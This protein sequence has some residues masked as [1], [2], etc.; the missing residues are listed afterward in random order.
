MCRALKILC[1]APTPSNL[2]E[3]KR[4]TVSV[5]WELVGGATSDEDLISQIEAWNPDVVVFDSRLGSDVER[6]V[7]EAKETV[8]VVVVD[9]GEGEDVY[10]KERIRQ[11]IVG[12]PQPGG[13]VRA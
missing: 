5:H 7:R 12:L 8:R 2:A 4:V 13:P 1:A 6:R 10:K 3:L 9:P 11:A